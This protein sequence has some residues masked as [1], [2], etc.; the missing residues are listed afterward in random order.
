MGRVSVDLD[1]GLG[2]LAGTLMQAVDVLGDQAGQPP[3][4]RQIGQRPVASILL[5]AGE[6]GIHPEAP[7]P[8]LQPRLLGCDELLVGDRCHPAPD[9][10]R[11]AEV[12]NAGFR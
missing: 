4:P 3:L 9:S 1:E 7:P 5:G 8:I 6:I 12:G 10:A 2:G 11:A